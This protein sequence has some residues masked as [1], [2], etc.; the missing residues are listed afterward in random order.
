MNCSGCKIG[1]FIP[2]MYP[3]D[4]YGISCLQEITQCGFDVLAS[5]G[6]H[7]QY[8]HTTCMT[9]FQLVTMN[10]SQPIDIFN[11]IYFLELET[12][13]DHVH[14]NSVK[15]TMVMLTIN[16]SKTTYVIYFI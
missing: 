5:L 3:I 14:Q 9:T 6:N 7:F 1:R 8:A 11:M 2:F 15:R 13:Y 4:I 16:I 10:N 12:F